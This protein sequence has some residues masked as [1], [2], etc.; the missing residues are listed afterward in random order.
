MG[1]FRT[2]FTCEGC[3][4]RAW[5]IKHYDPYGTRGIVDVTGSHIVK[6][7]ILCDKCYKR[8]S[9]AGLLKD[10]QEFKKRER[11]V[12]IATEAIKRILETS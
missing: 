7:K 12:S 11:S 8:A 9:L 6:G 2:R 3:G 1:E 4:C 10:I 5:Q